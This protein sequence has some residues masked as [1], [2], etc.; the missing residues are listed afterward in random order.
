MKKRWRK[1]RK[2]QYYEDIKRQYEK[3]SSDL[4]EWENAHP[5]SKVWDPEYIK[6]HQLQVGVNQLLNDAERRWKDARAAVPAREETITNSSAFEQLLR[7]LEQMPEEIANT[8][9]KINKADVEQ[10]DSSLTD[11]NLTRHLTIKDM[12]GA[13]SKEFSPKESNPE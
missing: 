10:K 3:V 5:D 6:M 4:K 2:E 12:S 9:V 1:K 7:K 8:I 11:S 13:S